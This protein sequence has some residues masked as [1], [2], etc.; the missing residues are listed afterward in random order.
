M[1]SGHYWLD[2]SWLVRTIAEKAMKAIDGLFH[3]FKVRIHF[4][5]IDA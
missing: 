2:G 5:R 1:L 4:K 3:A